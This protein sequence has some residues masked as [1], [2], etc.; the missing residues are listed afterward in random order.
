MSDVMLFVAPDFQQVS[1]AS[2][3]GDSAS[4]DALQTAIKAG[5]DTDY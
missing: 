2:L 3:F 1:A 5:K 4:F